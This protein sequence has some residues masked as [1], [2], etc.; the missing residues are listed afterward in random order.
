MIDDAKGDAFSPCAGLRSP[1]VQSVL[2]SAG[3]RRWLLGRR[4]N[5]LV[6]DAR[7]C[8]L[9]CRQGVRLTGSLS[10]HRKPRDK[11]SAGLVIL[12]HGWEGDCNSSYLLSMASHLYRRGFDVFRLNLRDHGGNHHLN[13][14]LFHA[15]RIDEVVDAV[16]RVAARRRDGR[17]FLGGYSLGGNFALRVALRAPQAGIT[18]RHV[19]AVSPVIDPAHAMQALEGGLSLYHRYFLHRWKASLRRKQRLFPGRYGNLP[20]RRLRTLSAM[21]EFF[22][23]Q[24]TGFR[25]SREY[26]AGYRL[27]R[28]QLQRLRVPATVVTSRDDPVIPFAD[29]ADLTGISGVDLVTTRFGGHCGFL[30]SPG[31]SVWTEPLLTRRLLGACPEPRP[32]VHGSLG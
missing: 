11:P 20:L 25:D 28:E 9:R 19:F 6:R 16:A 13:E 5:P 7:C 26:F 32:T 3:L 23:R 24:Y 17:S 29:F 2:A 30:A 1:H 22:V 15:C 31:L 12:I 27:D 18:L 10:L 8:I 4:A 14:D 21:T